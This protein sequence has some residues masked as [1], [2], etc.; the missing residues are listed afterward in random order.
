MRSQTDSFLHPPTA[1]RLPNGKLPGPSKF[2]LKLAQTTRIA[3]PEGSVLIQ[4]IS[5]YVINI[6]LHEYNVTRPCAAELEITEPAFFMMTVLKGASVLYDEVE[7]LVLEIPENICKLAYLPAGG[8]QRRLP[9]GEHTLLV[10]TL[11]PDWL[12]KKYGDQEELQELI[13]CYNNSDERCFGLPGFGI[14][15]QIF[16]ALDKLN[17]GTDLDIDMHIFMN[18]CFGR[19]RNRLQTRINNVEYQED[20]AKEIG[21]FILQNFASKLVDDEPALARHFMISTIT[22]MR[23]AKRH[24]GRPLHQQV[25][26][27][28]LLNGL[29]LLL[30]TNKTVQ[31]IAAMVGYEDANYFS[32][33]F[34]KRFELP[35]NDIRL[36]VF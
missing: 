23:L 14:G 27:L 5:H 4:S 19:Y 32:R 8:Y 3:L 9:D 6:Q 2:P 12:I 18:D 33:A 30:S 17:A 13:K 35:P 7:Q 31:E 24:F 28:R 15:Q 10:L 26:E 20:K 11:K 21:Q 22:L 25:I 16:S 34:K 36:F 1:A 29:K